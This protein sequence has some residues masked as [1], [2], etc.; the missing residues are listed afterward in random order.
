MTEPGGFRFD[1]PGFD[2]LAAALETLEEGFGGLPRVDDDADPAAAVA[3][4]G[5]SGRPAKPS[6]SASR[7]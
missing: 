1:R 7:A 5:S 3:L 6:S 2:E 4:P